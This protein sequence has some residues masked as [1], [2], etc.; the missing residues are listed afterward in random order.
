MKKLFMVLAATL[1]C[2][3]CVFTS[4]K[5]Q[6]DLN[7]KEKIIGKWMIADK[8]GQPEPTNRKGVI[9]FIST[10]KAYKS[11][12]YSEQTTHWLDFQEIDVTIDGN[13]I[14]LINHPEE[15]M[16]MV[17]TFVVTSITDNDF[18][19]NR[20]LTVTVDGIVEASHKEVVRFTKQTADHT[21]AILG[22]WECQELTGIETYNDANARLEFF[23][24]GNYNYWRKN[25][26]G[27][28]EPVTNRE[29]QNYFVDGTLLATRWK[30]IGE[31]ELREWWEIA[32]IANGEMQWTALRQNEDGTTAEQGMRWTKVD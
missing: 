9:T 26:A 17:E 27:E 21:A 19:A 2:G 3:A 31:Q 30:N 12:S 18:I 15:N 4:C 22:L 14:T 5:K 16:T 1:I 11:A 29:F 24:D 25:E 8:D 7:V 6:D 28:W 20:E 13:T 23:A 10:T 32:S